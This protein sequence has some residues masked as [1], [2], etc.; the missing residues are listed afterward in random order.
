MTMQRPRD[1]HIQRFPPKAPAQ[2]PPG[3]QLKGKKGAA[4][5]QTMLSE[6]CHPAVTLHTDYHASSNKPQP[7]SELGGSSSS[8]LIG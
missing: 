8:A 1:A 4:S 7:M 5:H 3:P 2:A 6:E